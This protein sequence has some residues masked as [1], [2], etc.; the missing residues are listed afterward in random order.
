[1]SS[2]WQ[3]PGYV[4][5]AHQAAAILRANNDATV[6]AI[7]AQWSCEQ[8]YPAPWP[9]IHNNP[10]NLTRLIGSLG[11]PPPPTAV[12]APGAGLLYAYP[13]ALAGAE[14]YATYLVRSSRYAGAL[15]AARRGDAHGFLVDVCASGYGTRLTCCLDQLG[16][17]TLPPPAPP[18]HRFQAA[19]NGIRVRVGPTTAAAVVGHV[20]EGQVIAG[21]LVNGGAY[22]GPHGTARSWIHETGSRYAAA[23]W[24]RPL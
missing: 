24:F 10:G 23:A 12:H 9:P 11:G 8:P 18:V 4:T 13:T 19:A 22:T 7:L 2:L 15:A 3:V 16:R 1:M 5:L 14:A 17:V 20:N 21:V 6:R